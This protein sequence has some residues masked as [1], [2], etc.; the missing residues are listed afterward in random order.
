MADPTTPENTESTV[1]S[2]AQPRKRHRKVSERACRRIIARH[3]RKVDWMMHIPEWEQLFLYGLMDLELPQPRR[4]INLRAVLDSL[5]LESKYQLIIWVF[6][7][8]SELFPA[9]IAYKLC[10]F[11]GIELFRFK[12]LD[13]YLTEKEWLR[14]RDYIH[15]SLT[16]EHQRYKRAQTIMFRR[17]Q[18]FLHK[19]VNRQVFDAAKRSD[20]YQ[21]ASLGLVHAIDKVDESDTAFSCYARTWISRHIRNFLMGEHFPVHVPINLAS[22]LLTAS[23][24]SSHETPAQK[25][26]KEERGEEEMPHQELL[27]PRVSLDA[28]ADDENSSQEIP[29]KECSDPMESASRKD[30]FKE[31]RELLEQ[32]TD[33]QREVIMLRYG[34]NADS[35]V[36]TLASVASKVGIS[37]QQVSMREKRALQKLETLLEPLREEAFQ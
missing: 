32:L 14:F 29:D 9:E 8:Y 23:S 6:D 37:H 34:I 10:D 2:A 33:K 31:V 12:D 28:M 24:K 13:E 16:W 25:R 27:K 3:R 26:E 21:E 1:S 5:P 19:L 7:S 30:L 20:A 36:H 35:Q 17:Y 22:K 18:S 4:G 15:A 11:Y